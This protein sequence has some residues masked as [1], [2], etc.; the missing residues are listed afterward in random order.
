LRNC[1]KTETVGLINHDLKSQNMRIFIQF[2]SSLVCSV[3]MGIFGLIFGATI[4]GNF[5]FPAFGGNVGYESGGVFF[6][7]VGLSLG[8]LLGMMIVKNIQKE[9]FSYK[10]AT[11]IAIVVVCISVVLFDYNMP[12]VVGLM[13][14]LLPSSVLTVVSVCKK[15]KI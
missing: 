10:L 4:G 12:R 3:L 6:A 14:V 13:I 9:K 7:I 1:H 15:G 2:M 5:G 11:I 8:S